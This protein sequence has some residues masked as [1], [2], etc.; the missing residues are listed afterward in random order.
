MDTQEKRKAPDGKAPPRAV[1]PWSALRDGPRKP[2][3]AGIGCFAGTLGAAESAPTQRTVTFLC[4]RLRFS[5]SLIL[6]TPST[7]LPIHAAAYR[8]KRPREMSRSDETRVKDAAFGGPS[9][10]R[11]V[12]G[13]RDPDSP[14]WD[15][16]TVGLRGFIARPPLCL[17]RS[18]PVWKPLGTANSPRLRKARCHRRLR[19]FGRVSH[20]RRLV[21]E[22]AKGTVA[23]CVIPFGYAFIITAECVS[24]RVLFLKKTECFVKIVRTRTPALIKERNRNETDPC[25]H[26]YVWP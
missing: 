18:E 12:G 15:A 9:G 22:I 2:R 7:K 13:I 19:S 10:A 16:L 17:P 11:V 4:E 14:P 24:Q 25:R 1:F 8:A 5:P 21:R 23:R 3:L 26:L 6:R 20:H